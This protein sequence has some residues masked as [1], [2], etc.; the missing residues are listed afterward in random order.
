MNTTQLI[1][2][3]THVSTRS[4][5]Q[6]PHSHTHA[7]I[8]IMSRYIYMKYQHL[9]VPEVFLLAV[10]FSDHSSRLCLMLQPL[11]HNGTV[12]ICMWKLHGITFGHKDPLFVQL[13][14]IHKDSLLRKTNVYCKRAV[15]KH[16]L[17]S[18]IDLS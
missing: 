6:I 4:H 12:S 8:Y 13:Y 18:L 3:H 10:L 17:K 5:V 14:S 15:I 16:S 9:K 1:F 2:T 7:K 11:Y